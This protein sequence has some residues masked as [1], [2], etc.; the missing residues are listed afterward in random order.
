MLKLAGVSEP[1]RQG[2]GDHA[3]R[4]PDR[5]GCTGAGRPDRAT[6]SKG[7][8]HWSRRTSAP[9][10]RGSTGRPTSAQPAWRRLRRFVVWQPS[11][12]TGISALV[13]S[14]P[15]E[16]WKDYLDVPRHP[17]AAAVLPVGVRQPVV[18]FLRGTVLTGAKQQRE[19]WKRAVARHQRRARLRGGPAVRR[20]LLP[21]GGEG[22]GS[23]RW[24]PTSSPP[25]ATASTSL[26]WMAPGHQAGGEGQAGRAQGGRRLS[27]PLARLLRARGEGRRCVRQRRAGGR[28]SSY[29]QS[30][31]KLGQPVDRSEWV[32]TPQPVNAVNLPAMNAMNFPAAI[33]QPPYFDPKR[34]RRMDYGAIGADHRPRGEPQLRQLRARCSI[35]R[36][37]CT[38]GGRRRTSSISRRQRPSSSRSTTQYRPFPDLAVNGKQTLGENIADLAGLT[39]AYDAYRRSQ[40]GK[41]APEG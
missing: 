8:N 37:G 3:A 10:R 4:D 31:A 28:C 27:R 15:L 11:A 22:A 41:P 17:V 23:R 38:T 9:R 13:A 40:G 26:E 2:R 34:P 39:A 24:S 1:G 16:T 21:A 30:L 32:M 14:E 5:A 19:R 36:A 12:V 33:L 6:C 25:S 35:P 7:N 18:R 29:R 20:A